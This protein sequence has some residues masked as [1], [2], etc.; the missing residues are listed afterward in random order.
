MNLGRRLLPILCYL[1][2]ATTLAAETRSFDFEMWEGFEIDLPEGWSANLQGSEAEGGPAIH[3]L[4]PPGAPLELLLTP[5]PFPGDAEELKTAVR[6][7]VEQAAEGLKPN[8]VEDQLAIREMNGPGCQALY[9]SATDR[10]VEVP[11]ASDFKYVDQGAAAVGPWMMT[12]TVFTNAGDAPERSR[13]LEVVRSSR[14]LPPGPPW[15]TLNAFLVRDGV[16][17]DVH[18]SKVSFR[19]EDQPLFEQV[20]ASVRFEP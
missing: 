19:P 18:L 12:F 5:F 14:H 17:I 10:T 4:P 16:W 2:S 8:A 13:A 6:N 1:A 7:A 3:I 9:F 15:R 20:V 11:S